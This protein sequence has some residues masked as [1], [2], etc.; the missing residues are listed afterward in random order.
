MAIEARFRGFRTTRRATAAWLAAVALAAAA[1]S[2]LAQERRYSV[3]LFGAAEAERQGFVR[4]VNRSAEAGSATVRAIDD[5]GGRRGPVT[6]EFAPGQARHFNSD[7]LQRGNADKGVEGIGAPGRGDWRLEVSSALDLEVLSYLRTKPGGFLT[8]MHDVAP[9]A[10]GSH[11]IAIFEPGGGANPS[12]KL[13]LVNAGD[14]AAAVTVRGVDDA[15]R[16]G[17]AELRLSLPAGESRTLDARDMEEGNAELF[18]GAL[19][20]GAGRWRLTVVADWPIQAMSLLDARDPR[21]RANLSTAPA[22]AGTTG[23]DAVHRVPLFPPKSRSAR[24]GVL[25]VVN[26]SAR[27]GA[28]RIEAV[29]DEGAGY[30]P[31]TLTIGAGETAHVDSADLE[32]GD[33]AKGLPVGVGDG[34]G[35]WRL[36]LST[37]LDVDVLAYVRTADGF[38]ASAHD[39]APSA[40]GRHRVSIFNPASNAN[41]RSA[42]RVVNDGG[43]DAAVEI[44]GVDDGG[45]AGADALR[46]VVPANAAREYTS[47]D[48]ESGALGDG[49]GKWRLTVESDRRIRVMSLLE[50]PGG[51]LTNLS[52][53]A[54][55]R[56]PVVAVLSDV[57]VEE[58]AVLEVAASASD[59]D[60]SIASWR[61]E[62]LSGPA[63]HLELTD[64]PRFAAVAPLVEADET[65]EFRVSATDDRGGVGAAAIRVL[66]T[67]AENGG[68]GGEDGEFAVG[69]TFR[70]CDECPEMVVV[71]AGSF[72]MGAPVSEP[73]SLSRERPVHEVTIAEPF[74]VGVYE[75]TFEE[76]D[77]CVADGGCG[78]HRPNDQG[79]GRGDRPA[80]L[81]NWGDAQSYVEWLSRRTGESY[82]LPSESEWEYV[83]RAGT[84]TAYSWGDAVGVNLANCYGCGSSWD[85]VSPAPVGSFDANPWGLHDVHGNVWEW[86]QD[87]WN[88]DYEGAPSDGSAWLSGTCSERVLRSGS[89]DY[90]PSSL[91]AA[92][93][94]KIPTGIRDVDFGLRVVRTLAP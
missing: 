35:D 15:G 34:S 57:E 92:N 90:V 61:W 71:P 87:C 77:A 46:V 86:V 88:A 17:A 28:V 8:S 60:G 65:A 62:Q 73:D 39:A 12:G 27:A 42:L 1:V 51:H 3:P 56:L 53:G 47:A 20:D 85:N 55:N 23:G 11:R 4:L 91:R 52:T 75:A 50:S 7:D 30:G 82:R 22:N 24:Q 58:G 6:L 59:P 89:W 25:R 94:I 66:V 76:W 32:D 83:A 36:A 69:E 18:Q 5:A 74:A 49:Q 63:F 13:R 38:L 29:D 43:E 84:R 68:N 48:L 10:D 9:E 14:E 26:R 33:A 44:A 19:G 78:G 40:G 79:W 93:R 41:Q 67:D 31:A 81:V 70:D 37:G 45:F 2:G 72:M 21:L 64:G 80:M 16:A 54:P